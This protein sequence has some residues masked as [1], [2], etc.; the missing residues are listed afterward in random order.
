MN[1]NST[2]NSEPKSSNSAAEVE[3][4]FLINNAKPVMIIKFQLNNEETKL[5]DLK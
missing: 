2:E 3:K 4:D 5:V 1:E